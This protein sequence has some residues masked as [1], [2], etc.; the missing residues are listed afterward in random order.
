MV[1]AS[2]SDVSLSGKHKHIRVHVSVVCMCV[3][4][5]ISCGHWGNEARRQQEKQEDLSLAE[6]HTHTHTHTQ[7]AEVH[8]ES[9]LAHLL[10]K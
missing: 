4:E 3:R 5:I 8:T 2:G 7:I 10:T 6:T 1:R 9:M